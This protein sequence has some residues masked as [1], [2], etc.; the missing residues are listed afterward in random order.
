[1][2]NRRRRRKNK[3]Y[4]PEMR[5]EMAK[6]MTANYWARNLKKFYEHIKEHMPEIVR[7]TWCPEV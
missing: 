1:M 4:T 6:K 2:P 5:K 7:T 3:I